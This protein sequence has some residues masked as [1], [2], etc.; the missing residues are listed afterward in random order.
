MLT[1]RVGPLRLCDSE[2]SLES[3]SGI[4]LIGQV[5]GWSIWSKGELYCANVCVHPLPESQAM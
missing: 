2:G 3:P 4:R 1:V 5:F